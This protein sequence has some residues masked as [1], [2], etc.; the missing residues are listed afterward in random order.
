VEILNLLVLAEDPS[1]LLL[2]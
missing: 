2:H 1:I